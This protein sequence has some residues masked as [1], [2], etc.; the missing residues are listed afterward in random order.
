MVFDN[1][2]VGYFAYN[3]MLMC[4]GFSSKIGRFSS[5]LLFV[6]VYRYVNQIIIHHISVICSSVSA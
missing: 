6:D 2:G 5:M 1:L 3:P 4:Y